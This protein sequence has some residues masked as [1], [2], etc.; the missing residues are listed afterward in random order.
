MNPAPEYFPDVTGFDWDEGNAE[1]NWER[2]AVSRAEAEQV[3]LNRPLVVANDQKHSVAEVRYFALGRS[4]EGRLLSVVFT[5]R[6]PLLRIIS[7][8]P[9]SR[10]EKAAYAKAQRAEGGSAL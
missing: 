10:R 9:M 2:H 8:R 7:V 6:G 1:K 5:L 3:F 4:D